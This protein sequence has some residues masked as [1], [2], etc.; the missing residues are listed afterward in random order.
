[1][2]DRNSDPGVNYFPTPS[3]LLPIMSSVVTNQILEARCHTLWLEWVIHCLRRLIQWLKCYRFIEESLMP[4]SFAYR[5][6]IHLLPLPKSETESV[7]IAKLEIK[8]HRD[9][10]GFAES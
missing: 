6:K 4:I 9:P 10:S 3:M 7:H 8:C 5:L 2:L 1:M